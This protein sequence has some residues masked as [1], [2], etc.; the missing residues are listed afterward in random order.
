M[1]HLAV[2]VGGQY[3]SEA[4]GTVAAYLAQRFAPHPTMAVRV[5][6]PNAGHTVYDE[7]GKPW[8]LRQMPTAAVSRPDAQLVVAAGS[9]IDPAVLWGEVAELDMAGFDV[10]N[11]LQIDDQAVIISEEHKLIE[12]GGLEHGAG[13]L[14][15]AIGS[16][17]KG[18]GAARAAHIMRQDVELYGG[19]VDTSV[20]IADFLKRKDS[21]PHV[22]IEGT[23]GY[24]LGLRAGFFP[25]C[26]S[27]D[28]RAVDFLAMAG[29]SP[30]QPGVT[31]LDIWVVLRTYPIRV[32][33]KSGPMVGELTWDR[34]IGR[35][36][37][38]IREPEKTTVTQKE[39][40]IA[41]WDPDLAVAAIRANGGGA[42]RQWNA[43]HRVQ[44]ALMFVDYVYPDVAGETK[45]ANLP[46]DVKAW[47]LNRERELGCYIGILGTGPTTLIDR[48]NGHG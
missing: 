34:M 38:Y 46:G 25:H 33:G 41:E 45:W 30:W 7:T 11:R 15:K 4:K 12:T 10:T 1:G 40:R 6:G 9:E 8:P 23:Q 24:G 19:G 32:A 29:I 42:G 31:T 36:N 35:T 28:C 26:T 13:G 18:I 14:T 39:R 20:E 43:N 17:G 5:A 48:G 21:R 3:G 2:V 27:S 22:I 47:V 44:A 16:T 37:G